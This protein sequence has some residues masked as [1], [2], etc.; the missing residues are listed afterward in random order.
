MGDAFRVSSD[1]TRKQGALR[2][3]GIALG[4]LFRSDLR[5]ELES[6]VRTTLRTLREAKRC[7]SCGAAV[8]DTAAVDYAM[9]FGVWRCAGTH[10]RHNRIDPKGQGSHG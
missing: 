2:L 1:E 8:V 5:A 6:L 3:L 4:E 7:M 9:R 10:C